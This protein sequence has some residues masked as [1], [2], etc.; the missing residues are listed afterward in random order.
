MRTLPADAENSAAT[1]RSSVSCS[2]P[3]QCSQPTWEQAA[4]IAEAGNNPITLIRFELVTH[5]PSVP[6]VP[7]RS[8]HSH[9]CARPC[10]RVYAITWEH[11]EHWEHGNRINRLRCS[12]PPQCSQPTWEQAAG[13]ATAYPSCDHDSAS[14]WPGQDNSRPAFDPNASNR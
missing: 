8:Q 3:P 5:V 12:Q 2:Q 6:R 13:I 10:A 11:W 7:S 4:G 1:I 14:T 9:M